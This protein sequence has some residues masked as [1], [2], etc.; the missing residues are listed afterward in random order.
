MPP[1]KPPAKRPAAQA[2]AKK[3]PTKTRPAG[4]VDP[5]YA[6]KTGDK[7]FQARIAQL[8]AGQAEAKAAFLRAPGAT[9]ERWA[10][11][12]AQFGSTPIGITG[13][14]GRQRII[15]AYDYGSG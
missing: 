4:T 15:G 10:E 5:V 8:E 2:P 6:K 9:E 11:V 13:P 3:A 1:R 14:G 7:A 12:M